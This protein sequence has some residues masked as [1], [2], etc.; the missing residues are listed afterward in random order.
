M[1]NGPFDAMKRRYDIDKRDGPILESRI[2]V[3]KFDNRKRG[4]KKPSV[5]N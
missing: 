1:R 5:Q 4:G 3:I 2:R